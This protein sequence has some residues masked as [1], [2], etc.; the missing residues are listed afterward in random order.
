MCNC[1]KYNEC[2]STATRLKE[3]IETEDGESTPGEDC[4]LLTEIIKIPL[5]DIRKILSDQW[6]APGAYQRTTNGV[7][8]EYAMT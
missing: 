1:R 8:I 7:S 4:D 5:Q 6:E 3:I 2:W